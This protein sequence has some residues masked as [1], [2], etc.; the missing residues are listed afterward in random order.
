MDDELLPGLGLL[1][2]IGQQ[3][4]LFA[5]VP[6]RAEVVGECPAPVAH[7]QLLA[8]EPH[9][10]RVF[11]YY[12]PPE[13]NDDAVFGVRVVVPLGSRELEGIIVA[14]DSMSIQGRTE[15]RPIKRVVSPVPVFSSAIASFAQHVA[16]EY[17]ASMTDIVRLALP[18]RHARAEKEFYEQPP[19]RPRSSPSFTSD[20]WE[21]YSGGRHFIDELAGGRNARAVCCAL[22]GAGGGVSLLAAAV[23]ATL[24]AGKSAILISPT[25][26][27]ASRLA[28]RLES[29]LDEPVTLMLSGD[30]PHTRYT[31]FLSALTGKAR[32]VVGTRSAI[33]APVR[34]LGLLVV[35]DDAA[36]QLRESRSPYCHARDLA[37]SR[38]FHEGCGLLVFSSYVTEE[39][40]A[41]VEE[42][43]A[44][45]LEGTAY[46]V[47]TYTP[48]VSLAEQWR[49]GEED[50]HRIP[51]PVFT[52]VRESLERGPV[53]LVVP[54][55]GYIPLLACARCRERAIC[56]LCGGKL[57]LTQ[58]ASHPVCSRCGA[59]TEH[60]RCG[61]CG[62]EKVRPI[63]I[64]SERTAQD[65]ARAFP[66]VGIIVSSGTSPDGIISTVSARPR[67]VIATPGGEPIAEGGYAAA[68]ILE[69]RFLQGEGLGAETQLIRSITRV[70]S[71][72]RSRRD[73][74]HLMLAGGADPSLVAAVSSWA[75]GDYA[76]RLLDER[77]HLL[78]PPATA[79]FGVT[80]AKASL[81]RFLALLRAELERSPLEGASAQ[82]VPRDFLLT[83][84]IGHLTEGVDMLGPA[85]APRDDES[86]VYLRCARAMRGELGERIGTAHRAYAAQGDLPVRIEYSPILP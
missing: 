37:F 39:S 6:E 78:L 2:D 84:G 86:T 70:A 42:G 58:G 28:E 71:R 27:S 22:S 3:E 72:V 29:L 54:R 49:G 30:T 44:Q 76:H 19:S 85:P 36:E 56:S 14:R 12:V 61:A 74:A 17:G 60:Y 11:D 57:E 63:R 66:G 45:L 55:S 7:V 9:L 68:I 4:A 41:Y 80:G 32:I 47:A 59:K 5:S 79:W 83:G 48:R 67:L 23:A 18:P 46:A 50:T 52:L 77:R 13:L 53:L 16:R 8:S 24:G 64:G 51:S 81:R 69:A 31:A 1:P 65:V 25:Q 75:L 62:C 82:P 73:G 34:D 15:L 10:A 26:R 43:S 35:L 40:M 20:L 21:L 38:S 33:W